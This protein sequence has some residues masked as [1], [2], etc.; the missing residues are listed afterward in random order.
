M[1]MVDRKERG[2]TLPIML[3]KHAYYTCL[4]YQTCNEVSHSTV[5]AIGII[6][7]LAMKYM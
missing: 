1:P 4:C 5:G 7:T 3:C 2:I 6:C